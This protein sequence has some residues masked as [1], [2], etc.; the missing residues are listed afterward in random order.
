M[1]AKRVDNLVADTENG[2]ERIHC[3]LGDQG[4]RGQAQPPHLLFG[5]REEIDPVEQGFARS[6]SAPAA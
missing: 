3:P 1:I 6:L 2:V 4:D 5:K